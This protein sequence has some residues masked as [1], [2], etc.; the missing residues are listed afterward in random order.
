M[1]RYKLTKKKRTP[2]FE[3]CEI[4]SPAYKDKETNVTQL[5]DDAV[6]EGRDW[7]TYNKL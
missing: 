5:S 4:K 3:G 2:L 1:K 6:E 7:V